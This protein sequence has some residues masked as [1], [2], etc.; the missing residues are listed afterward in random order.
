MVTMNGCLNLSRTFSWNRKLFCDWLIKVRHPSYLPALSYKK[1]SSYQAGQLDAEI[2]A[3]VCEY[4][5]SIISKFVLVSA[6]TGI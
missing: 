5:Y 3:A 6:M 2:H 1:R 4:Q